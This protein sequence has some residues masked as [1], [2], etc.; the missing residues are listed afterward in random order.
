M[1]RSASVAFALIAVLAAGGCGVVRPAPQPREAADGPIRRVLPNGIAVIV[2]K[3]PDSDVV[4]VQLW[5]RAGGRDETADEVG[6]AHYLEHMLFKGTPSRPAGVLDRE[7]EGRGGRM[8]AATSW[9]YTVY[10][11][12]LPAR[13][14]AEGI[15]ILGDVAVNANLDAATLEAEKQVVL[16]EIRLYED[17]PRRSLVERLYA[18]AFRAHPYGRPLSGSPERIR[19]LTR[20]TLVAFYRQH[21]GPQ[22]FALVIVGP[23]DP[24]AVLR[25]AR[26]TFGRLPRAATL[27]L[28]PPPP[29]APRAA[30]VEIERP[31][32]LA[33]IG[34]AWQAPR[35]EHAEMPAVALMTAILGGGPASRLVQSVRERHAIVSAIDAEYS[36]LQGAGLITVIAQTEP[37]RVTAA[38]AEILGEIR[39]L[40]NEGVTEAERRRALT[41]AEAEHEFSIERAEGRAHALGR[42]ETIWRL[43]DEL[44][45]VDR[46]RSV[47]LDPLRAVARRYLDPQQYTRVVFVP[48][49]GRR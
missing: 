5:V 15:D 20:D 10:H 17:S 36:P 9:D 24:D 13:Q 39:R 47:T 31:G 25:R 41:A 23:V 12:L 21:Y 28:P 16:E 4:A 1:A 26:E 46:L 37:E 33:Y 19:A 2:D 49:T 42:A 27:G 22:S 44:L 11:L 6:L 34:L 7:V 30:R 38:E 3:R 18:E 32:A 35:L 8:N 43:E 29:P 48:P 14:T 45:Y 40:R